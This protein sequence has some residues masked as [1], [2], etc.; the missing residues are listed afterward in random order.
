MDCRTVLRLDGG[1]A[2][3]K[4]PSRDHVGLRLGSVVADQHVPDEPERYRQ[5]R[6]EP[7][8][9][10][11]EIL[12]IRHGESEAADPARPFPLVDGRGDPALSPLGR[13]QAIRVAE[14]LAITRVDAIYVTSL[15][16]TAET[17]APLAA[18]L[19][20]VPQVEPALAEVNLGEWE[21]GLYRQRVAQG[22]PVVVQMREEERWDVIPGAESNLEIAAR[23]G[24]AIERIAK[25]HPDQRVACFAHGGTIGAV[26][27]IATGSRPFAFIGSDNGAISAMV[28]VGSHWLLRGFNDRSHLE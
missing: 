5:V 11:T 14:R 20:I 4:S 25:S 1:F 26:L 23:V 6:F 3:W 2:K 24:P 12:L 28:V 10:S 19:G 13:Q 9:G 27:A 15:R 22:D 18:R 17:A 21:G 7:P 16:R 8:S